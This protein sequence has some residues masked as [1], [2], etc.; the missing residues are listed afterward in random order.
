MDEVCGSHAGRAVL[1]M[2]WDLL[3]CGDGMRHVK[4]IVVDQPSLADCVSW[5]VILQ[6]GMVRIMQE[7]RR[8]RFQTIGEIFGYVV[9][10]R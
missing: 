1:P 3:S 10:T 9:V 6:C 8:V 5:R 7:M 4:F 2:G